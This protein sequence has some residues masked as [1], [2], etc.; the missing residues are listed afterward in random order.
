MAQRPSFPW[1]VSLCRGVLGLLLGSLLLLGGLSGCSAA[2]AGLNS[3]QS[4]DGRYAFLYPTGWSRV[5][6]SNGPQVVF[7]DLINSDETLSLVITEV[8]PTNDLESLGSAVAVGEKLGRIVI[9]PEGSGRE[10]ELVEAR[11]RQDGGHTFYDLEYAVHLSDRDRHELATVV[12]DRGRLYTLAAS[13]NE[14]RW[15]KVRDLFRNVITS[16]TLQI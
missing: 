11:E 12:V 2:A 5:A 8:N 4:P 10:A 3:F 14:L 6:V 1:L 13:T 16:F 9:A 15:P 7:H